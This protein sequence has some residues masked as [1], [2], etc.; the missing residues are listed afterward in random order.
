MLGLALVLGGIGSSTQHPIASS[1]IASAYEARGSRNALGTYNFA[2]DLGKMVLPALAACLIAASTWRT[3]TSVIGVGSLV[4]AI[5][6][7]LALPHLR[8]SKIAETDTDNAMRTV[9]SSGLD[10]SSDLAR[11]VGANASNK[12]W[13]DDGARAAWCD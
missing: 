5:A 2:G 7:I 4:G 10:L 9:P 13:R 6:I 12:L 8:A 11:K 1:L 3:T